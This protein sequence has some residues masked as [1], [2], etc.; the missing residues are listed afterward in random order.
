MSRWIVCLLPA[1]ALL[2]SGPVPADAR[3]TGGHASLH[4]IGSNLRHHRCETASPAAI[5]AST[6][7]ST[8]DCPR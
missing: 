1:L 5:S 7:V 3:G 2:V 8:A 6:T 4:R